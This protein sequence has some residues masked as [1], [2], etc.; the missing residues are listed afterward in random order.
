[1]VLLETRAIVVPAGAALL[2]GRSAARSAL[3][4]RPSVLSPPERRGRA[5]AGPAIRTLERLSFS[6]CSSI[7]CGCIGS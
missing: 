1:M 5:A 7:T 2:T 4:V 6:G 3:G